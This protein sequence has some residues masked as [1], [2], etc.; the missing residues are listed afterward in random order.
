MF[1]IVIPGDPTAQARPRLFKRGR[2]TMVYDPQGA[3]KSSL[4]RIVREQ[5]EAIDFDSHFQYPLLNFWFYMP[6][7]K[8]MSKSERVYADIE[9]LRHIKK[10]DVDNLLKLYID[11]MTPLVYKDDNCVSLSRAIKLYSKAPRTVIVIKEMDK[12][13]TPEE[14]YGVAI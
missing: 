6:I 8:S 4:K 9:R 7:P 10:P 11:V 2:K 14:M 5:L 1:T 12:I 3:F 13:V